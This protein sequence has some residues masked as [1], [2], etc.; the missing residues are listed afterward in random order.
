MRLQLEQRYHQQNLQSFE[1]GQAINLPD[2]E[3]WVVC[4]GVVTLSTS[5]DNGEESLLGLVGPSGIFGSPLSEIYP[6]HASALSA[7]DLLGLSMAELEHTPLLCQDLFRSLNH[8]LQQSEKLLAIVGQRRVEDRLRQFLQLLG[9]E[10]GQNQGDQIRLT[11]RLTHQHLANA[12][13][14]TRVTVTRLLG[15]LRQEGVLDFDTDRH[16]LLS[17]R[18]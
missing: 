5:Y 4:R 3:V 8:R 13:G 14:T 15:Q 12:L 7:V 10:V 2:R 9:Q 17:L 1:A 6:Y 16:L 18:A 11:V